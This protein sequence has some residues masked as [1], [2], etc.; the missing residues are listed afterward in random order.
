MPVAAKNTSSEATRSSVNE[1]LLEI[2]AGVEGP[3]ALRFVARGKAALDRPAQALDRGR[4]DDALRGTA[5]AEQQVNPGAVAG[6]HDHAG[7]VAVGDE[8]YPGARG[9]DV[10]DEL[11]VPGPVQDDHG[12]VLR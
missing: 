10:G 5:D 1:H 9:P 12:H 6:G 7:H 4:G 11:G 2:V 8:L 3:L